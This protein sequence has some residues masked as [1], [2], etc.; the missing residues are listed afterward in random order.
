[1]LQ[2]NRRIL[3]RLK[4][5]DAMDESIAVKWVPEQKRS[6]SQTIV[7]IQKWMAT[8]MEFLVKAILDFNRAALL[9]R[10]GKS[11]LGIRR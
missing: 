6:S 7:Q 9:T 1:M 2:F 11:A 3:I 10:R 4:D 5:L 8:V